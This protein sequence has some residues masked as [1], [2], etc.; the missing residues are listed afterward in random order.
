MPPGVFATIISTPCKHYLQS[1]FIKK[2]TRDESL[3]Q[4]IGFSICSWKDGEKVRKN[5]FRFYD[6]SWRIRL[7]MFIQKIEK[8][9]RESINYDLI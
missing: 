2:K 1:E 6:S 3:A 8:V 5:T 9:F 7:R 4:L